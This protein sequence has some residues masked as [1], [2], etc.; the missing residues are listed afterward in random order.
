[1]D[2]AGRESEQGQPHPDAPMP[3]LDASVLFQTR[4]DDTR[5]L[6]WRE[7]LP[8]TIRQSLPMPIVL[9]LR[10]GQS[11]SPVIAGY[12]AYPADEVSIRSRSMNCRLPRPS[13]TAGARVR[14]EHLCQL[15]RLGPPHPGTADLIQQSNHPRT[16][17]EKA[18]IHIH[19]SRVGQKDEFVVM[20]EHV[21]R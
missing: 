6:F 11:S 9:S 13:L 12:A 5:T 21:Y 1:M 2:P 16:I 4:R 19:N 7:R 17:D 15:R 14:T 10:K 3:S 8:F 20:R 18:L